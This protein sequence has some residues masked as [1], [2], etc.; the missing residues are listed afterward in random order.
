MTEWRGKPLLIS[1]S[2]IQTWKDCRRKWYL[3]YYREMGLRPG[4]ATVGV[5]SLG[6]KVHV[7][8]ASH[9]ANGANPITVIRALYDLDI[10][11]VEQAE[12][13][14]H[15]LIIKLKKELD[16]ASAM[17][18]GYFL[19]VQEEAI[20]AGLTF[21]AAEDVIEVASAIPGVRLRGKMD[22]RWIREVDSA[23][24]YRDFKTVADLNSPQKLLPLDEQMKFYHLL[25]YLD[26]LEKT[27]NEPQWRTDGALYTM[28]RRV[29]RTALAKPPFYG[30]VEVKH[31]KHELL[32]IWKR[33]HRVI[34]EIIEA[35][36]EI[37]NTGDHQEIFPPRP[38][39]DCIWKCDF[40]PICP[41]MDDGSNWEGMLEEHYVHTDPHDRYNT[42][43]DIES[44]GVT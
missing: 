1:N 7:A 18:E 23:R 43:L 10:H 44:D 21:V 42:V 17:L 40:L 6:T 35:R 13:V 26:S 5:R 11:N 9:Y 2:E 41:M 32:S 8:L 16:L 33:V 24:L 38:S 12:L 39:R 3:T 28:L 4:A 31:N 15:S 20:D 27:S 30:Q 34:K 19:W 36:I 25:E 37:A 22:Q 14:D 29:K